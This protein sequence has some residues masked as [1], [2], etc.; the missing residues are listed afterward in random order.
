MDVVAERF[1]SAA[2][3]VARNQSASSPERR[4]RS[5][6][7]AR[8]QGDPDELCAFVDWPKTLDLLLSHP[9]FADRDQTH[10]ADGSA[11]GS[12]RQS[13]LVGPFPVNLSEGRWYVVLSDRRQVAPERELVGRGD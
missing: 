3:A 6:K 11:A 8:S 2:E 13:D 5:A 10:H 12:G 9:A 1:S 7:A 4:H